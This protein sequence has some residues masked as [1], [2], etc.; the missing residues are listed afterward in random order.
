MLNKTVAKRRE[1][2]N[3]ENVLQNIAKKEI[4]IE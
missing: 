2:K 1:K 4:V 3:K